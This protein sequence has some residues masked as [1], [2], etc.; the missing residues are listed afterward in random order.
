MGVG[1]QQEL[2]GAS[3][4]R[5]LRIGE[6]GTEALQHLSDLLHRYRKRLDGLETSKA[7]FNSALGQILS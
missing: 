1:V 4:V 3:F 5:K 6:L 7:G 2:D